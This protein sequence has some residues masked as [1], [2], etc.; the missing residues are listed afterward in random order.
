MST[1]NL[2]LLTQSH[3]AIAAKK[4]ARR[5]QVKEIVFDDDARRDF[6]T[7]FHKRKKAKADA[8]RKRAQERAKQEHLEGRR[9]VR[10]RPEPA[11]HRR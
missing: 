11:L 3:N 4:N 9:E 10:V 6:L 1:N 8:A 2:A 7:G 5:G